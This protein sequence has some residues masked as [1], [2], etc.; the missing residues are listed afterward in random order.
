MFSCLFF[1]HVLYLTRERLSLFMCFPHFSLVSLIFM[2]DFMI[3]DLN[4]ISLHLLILFID[5]ID[6][7]FFISLSAFLPRCCVHPH[8]LRRISR[9]PQCC[10]SLLFMSVYFCYLHQHS[11]SSHV[12]TYTQILTSPNL[13]KMITILLLPHHNSNNLSSLTL[14][15]HSYRSNR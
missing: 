8:P 13:H 12:Y 15:F 5:L 3:F 10:M 7:P 1:I 6:F 4:L 11:H 14:V 9:S 2:F